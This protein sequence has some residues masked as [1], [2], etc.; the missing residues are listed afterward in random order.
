LCG[1]NDRQ[2]QGHR[3]IQPARQFLL[4]LNYLLVR[5]C[6]PGAYPYLEVKNSV[7]LLLHFPVVVPLDR[8][9]YP[10][11][12]VQGALDLPLQSRAAQRLDAKDTQGYRDGHE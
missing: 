6:P 5:N 10:K 11:L 12:F 7:I 2:H 1:G 4:E 9:Q 3:A 8:F